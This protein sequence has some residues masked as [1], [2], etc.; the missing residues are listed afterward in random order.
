VLTW[1]LLGINVVVWL[2]MMLAGGSENTDVLVQFGA[3]VNV[4]IAQ[5]EYWRL[6][7]SCF[8]H[9]GIMHLAFNAYAL[10]VFGTEAEAFYGRAR[11]LIIY[12]LAG[13]FG[14]LVSFAFNPGVSAGASG[15]IFGLIGALAAF[16]RRQHETFGAAAQR[17]LMSMVLVAGLNVF[18]G[19]T[20]PGIDNFAHLGGLAAGLLLGWLLSPRYEAALRPDG[21][22]GVVDRNGLRQRWWAVLLAVVVFVGSAALSIGLQADSADVH[23]FRGY[24]ALERG[25]AA[26]AQAEFQAAVERAPG[27]ASA[28][29]GLGSAYYDQ[30]QYDLAAQSYRRALELQPGLAG[31]HWNLALCY[32]QL[33]RR[34][35]AIAELQAYIASNP[36]SDE[37]RQAEEL[38]ATLRREVARPYRLKT[39]I[40]AF[41]HRACSISSARCSSSRSTVSSSSRMSAICPA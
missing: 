17:R 28:Y 8:L 18:I 40:C 9:V 11:F 2:L 10:F 19:F 3:K 22:F 35:E 32:A 34:S 29:F 26:Q 25:Q 23:V 15:A 4:L 1:L 39:T 38:I 14:S 41:S 16:Y 21:S 30:G 37:V 12:L 33:G 31:A 24:Q 6:L 7:T 27:S 36:G 20:T 5:G 13:L